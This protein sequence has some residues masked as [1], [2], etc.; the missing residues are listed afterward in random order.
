MLYIVK[1]KYYIVLNNDILYIYKT[2]IDKN[3]IYI[4]I[5]THYY[6]YKYIANSIPVLYILTPDFSYLI[7][8]KQ[9]Y[10]SNF[11]QYGQMEKQRWE[12]SEKRR[13]EKKREDQRKER[14][15]RRKMQGREKVEK[16]RNTV[17]SMFFQ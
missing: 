3:Y 5:Y 7:L 16:S 12:E 13:E 2:I 11:R 15:R 8:S 1:M 9:V 4:Y 14:V 10:K 6:I 17:F